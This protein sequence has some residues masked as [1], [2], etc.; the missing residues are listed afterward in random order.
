MLAALLLLA[1][2]N[3]WE[4]QPRSLADCDARVLAHPREFEA[5][6]CYM[7]VS[8]FQPKAAWERK[9]AEHLK[10]RVAAEPDEPFAKLMLALIDSE[11]DLD[12]PLYLASAPVFH[13]Q[14]LYGAEVAARTALATNLCENGRFIEADEQL[15]LTRAAAVASGASD[16]LSQ[17]DVFDANCARVE[18][19]YVRSLALYQRARA[20]LLEAPQT[21]R[22]GWL[23]GNTFDGLGQ[24]YALT[25]RHQ[26]AL[27]IFQQELEKRDPFMRSCAEHR[28]AEEAVRLARRG[29]LA[30]D[31]ADALLKTALD[32]EVK[33]GCRVYINGGEIYTRLLHAERLGPTDE[34]IAEVRRALELTR[35]EAEP[36]RLCR[37]LRLLATLTIERD[38]SEL[39]PALAAVD[40]AIALATQLGS[41]VERAESLMTRAHVQARAGESKAALGDALLALEQFDRL[42]EQQPDAMVRARASTEW[43]S[44]Y[45]FVAGLLLEEGAPPEQSF[46]TLERMR[47]RSLLELLD[48]PGAPGTDAKATEALRRSRQEVLATLARLQRKLLALPLDDPQRAQALSEERALE[49]HEAA[50]RE[51]LDLARNA[52]PNPATRPLPTLAEVQAQLGE[53]E[54]MLIFQLFDREGA[55]SAYLRGS[56]WVLAISKSAVRAVRIPEA[57]AERLPGEVDLLAGLVARRDGSEERGARTL[58]EQLLDEALQSLGPQLARLVVIPDG[59]LH[60][61]PFEALRD[62]QGRALGERFEL[63]RAPS[64]ALFLRWRRTPTTPAPVPALA[65][66]DPSFGDPAPDPPAA[67]PPD[68]GAAA[69]SADPP[70]DHAVAEREWDLARLRQPLPGARAEALSLVRALGHGS[71]ARLGPDATE[72]FVKTADLRRFGILHLAAH[73]RID[74]VRP[75][76]SAILLAPGA[77][78]EDGLLQLGEIGQLDLRG[79]A[80]VLATCSSSSGEVLQGEGVMS[81]ARGFFQAGARAVVGSLWPLRDDDAALFFDSFYARLSEGATLDDAMAT[82]RRARIRAGA[83]AEAWAGLTLL[84]DGQSAPIARSA[85]RPFS[86]GA[87]LAAL[88]AAVLFA[89][90][91]GAALLR[92]RRRTGPSAP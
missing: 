23:L 25:G 80:V 73:A 53:G 29:G 51:Q 83:P 4:F 86:G 68:A 87:A 69:S 92:R 3:P 66:G 11:D 6:F 43:S 40:E 37:A 58:H 27:E 39:K 62:A 50:L 48:R 91:L 33:Y 1:T 30:W 88:S 85:H 72:R 35:K 63:A 44:A 55:E 49:S 15:R 71:E 81:L 18:A 75:E 82:A 34:G 70:E 67:A 31:D 28:V 12:E 17:A 56:S 90:A 74:E 7:Q 89:L 61:L 47:A 32:D 77:P 38:K 78:D 16:L 20:R 79:S 22:T 8:Y 84:G 65:L 36:I 21:W 59:P 52:P 2:L 24:L 13:A 41:R 46:Q 9:T 76:R 57:V 64:A 14:Q 42:R 45:H 5:W 10:A 60:R 19:D 26:E 54:G